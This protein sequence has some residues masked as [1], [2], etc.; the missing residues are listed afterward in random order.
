MRKMSILGLVGIEGSA[1]LKGFSRSGYGLY[2]TTG[3]LA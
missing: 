2:R 3:T 1:E